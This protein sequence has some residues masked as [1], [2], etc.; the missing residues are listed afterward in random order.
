MKVLDDL[1]SPR[2]FFVEKSGVNPPM[3]ASLKDKVARSLDIR[4]TIPPLCVLKAAQA[5]RSMKEG[6]TTEIL[7]SDPG[8][9]ESLFKVLPAYFCELVEITEN[10]ACCRIL[11]RKNQ[12]E[13]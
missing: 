8:V 3:G 9:R 12:E 4:M 7:L 2:H 1:V 6:E 5:F 10:K 11:V 13:I